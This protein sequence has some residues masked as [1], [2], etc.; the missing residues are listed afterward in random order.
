MATSSAPSEPLSVAVVRCTELMEEY[1]QHLLP[2]RKE[3]IPN[4]PQFIFGDTGHEM[5]ICL[6]GQMFPLRGNEEGC[7]FDFHSG[8][9]KDMLKELAEFGTQSKVILFLQNH[10][11]VFK[12]VACR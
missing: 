6:M 12:F 3:W 11:I 1:E 9:R 10:L 4:T 8:K 5:G 7:E 2:D